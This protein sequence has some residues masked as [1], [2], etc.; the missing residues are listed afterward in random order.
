MMYNE[1]KSHKQQEYKD[2]NI[3]ENLD[4]LAVV[5]FNRGLGRDISNDDKIS[6]TEHIKD[7]APVKLIETSIADEFA[8]YLHK[9]RWLDVLYGPVLKTEKD[10]DIN[11]IC[12]F[13][14]NDTRENFVIVY[15][16]LNP[17]GNL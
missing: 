5:L 11:K 2:K 13:S 7:I 3:K 6:I 16:P 15:Y 17:G 4:K 8:D 10:F 14:G 9:L 1:Y 12:I